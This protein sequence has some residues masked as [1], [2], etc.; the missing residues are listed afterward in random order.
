MARRSPPITSDEESPSQ[1]TTVTA[2]ALLSHVL[3]EARETIDRSPEQISAAAG[4]SGRTIR[5]LEAGTY[6]RRPRTVTLD[7][8]GSFYGLN[9][10]FLRELASWKSLRGPALLEQLARYAEEA[11]GEEAAEWWPVNGDDAAQLTLRLARRPTSQR[12]LALDPG[13]GK[14]GFLTAWNAHLLS[15]RDAP[16]SQ[17]EAEVT[18]LLDSYLSLD[19]GRRRTALSLLRD[20]RLAREHERQTRG[21]SLDHDAS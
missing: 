16:P 10:G 7:T 4:V 2:R 19:R 12:G 9:A 11:L 6:E 15:A 21:V 3:R 17:E 8:L 13:A 1:S 20:L 18:E 14:A 5:R